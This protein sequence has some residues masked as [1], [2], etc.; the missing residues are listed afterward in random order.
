MRLLLC[1]RADRLQQGIAAPLS[2]IV[3][4]LL[5]DPRER[6]AHCKMF[7]I[8]GLDRHVMVTRHRWY[9][10]ALTVH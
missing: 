2:A 4:S 6:A 9:A 8:G 10:A 5:G 7:V 1:A 3:R